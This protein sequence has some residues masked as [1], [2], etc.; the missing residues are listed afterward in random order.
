MQHPVTPYRHHHD[1]HR[2]IV[3][4][5]ADISVSVSGNLI[6]L[7]SPPISLFHMALNLTT[8]LPD[9]YFHTVELFFPTLFCAHVCCTLYFVN[10]Y[11][12][13]GGPELAGP[14]S[15]FLD[16]GASL[17]GLCMVAGY[18]TAMSQEKDGMNHCGQLH[19]R[20]LLFWDA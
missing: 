15:C 2:S 14:C 9:L 4:S 6:P 8:P 16:P 11:P 7:Q 20:R 17:V 12:L 18:E 1:R 10:D 13:S 3:K 5:S 19:R